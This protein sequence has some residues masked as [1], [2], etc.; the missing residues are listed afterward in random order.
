MPK[1]KR[2]ASLSRDAREP[3]APPL[4]KQYV[5]YKSGDKITVRKPRKDPYIPFVV[6]PTSQNSIT[7]IKQF[8]KHVVTDIKELNFLKNDMGFAMEENFGDD[9]S[10]DPTI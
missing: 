8:I 10:T 4:P 1:L 6:Q 2:K 3:I 9:H 7:K 5:V